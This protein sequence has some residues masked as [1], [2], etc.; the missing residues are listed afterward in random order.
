MAKL[1]TRIGVFGGTF[2]P[3]HVGHQILASEALDVL[4]L[5]KILWVLTP[6]PPHKTTKEMATLSERKEMVEAAIQNDDKFL[7]STV[8]IDRPAPHYAVDTVNILHEEYPEAVL[9]YLMGGDSLETLPTWHDPKKLIAACDEIGVMCRPGNEPNLSDLEIVLPGIS[10]KVRF[11]SA[12]LLEISSSRIRDRIKQNRPY[13]YFLPG[14]VYKIIN[15][16]RL[17]R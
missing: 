10:G 3:P 4:D 5:D 1:T 8:D 7:F 6:D 15:I 11:I 17:Y 16:Q 2:D 12:P 9:C 13:R 14:Q